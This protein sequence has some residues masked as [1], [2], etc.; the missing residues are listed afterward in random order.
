MD[1]SQSM[2][3]YNETMRAVA[4]SLQVNIPY[5]MLVEEKGMFDLFLSLGLNPELGM[6]IPA[7][8]TYGTAHLQETAMAFGEAGARITIHGPFE[9][10]DPGSTDTATQKKSRHYL[11]RLLR[12]VE[13]MHPVHVVC[14]TGFHPDTH[15][16]GIEGWRA[17]SRTIW[18]EMAAYIATLKGH[19]LLE[20][21]HESTPD[22]MAKMV[23]GL[24]P[25]GVCLDTGHLNAYGDGDLRGWIKALGPLTR[26]IHLHD[27]DGTRDA[28]RPPGEGSIDFSPLTGLIETQ[29]PIITLEPHT[30]ADLGPTINAIVNHP[31][32]WRRECK[33]IP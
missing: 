13:V 1:A 2:A 25:L 23:T 14:H 28:H 26:E 9:G 19:L 8:D 3:I 31:R 5:R 18:S 30:V 7:L 17:R 20:N 11:E 21:V 24:T 6:D 27:N 33:K 29:H 12:A 15:T 10:V 22:E 16:M 32:W 4:R